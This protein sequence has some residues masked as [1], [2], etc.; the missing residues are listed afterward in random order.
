MRAPQPAVASA[1]IFEAVL[2]LVRPFAAAHGLMT[3][4]RAVLVRLEDP[5]GVEG[6]GECGA[7]VTEY[8]S[9]ETPQTAWEDLTNRLV[10]AL[11]THSEIDEPDTGPMARASLAAALVDL[12]ARRDGLPLATFLGGTL[13]RVPVGAVLGFSPTIDELMAEA[14]AYVRA[15][16]RRI[17]VKIQPGWDAQPIEALRKNWPNLPLAADANGSY[18]AEQSAD[19]KALDRFELDFLEQP[20]PPPALSDHARLAAAL[21]TPVCLDESI[22]SAEDARLAIEL[23]AAGLIVV[24]AARLG[25]VAEAIAVHDLCVENGIRPWV[26]GMLETG[27]GRGH[28]VALASLPGFVDPADLS[29]SDRYFSEDLVT[30]PWEV[31]DGTLQPSTRPGLGRIIDQNVLHRTTVR[32]QTFELL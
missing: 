12:A 32:K 26:G 11:K 8:S 18:R 25:G 10:P 23:G 7:D 14:D 24:K 6:W 2:P 30:P 27:V 22:S 28:A 9:P 13:R 4:R 5:D 1:E 29:G 3:E 17:K 21:H 20:L 31:T 15:G 19:L 16:Y